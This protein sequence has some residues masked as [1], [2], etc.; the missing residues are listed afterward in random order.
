MKNN[1]TRSSR[2]NR[3]WTLI[4]V[5]GLALIV[6]NHKQIR[7]LVTRIRAHGRTS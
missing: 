2:D 5:L 3:D 4:V 7:A 1:D 6:N